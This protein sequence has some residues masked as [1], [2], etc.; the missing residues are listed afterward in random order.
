MKHELWNS[1]VGHFG[2]KKFKCVQNRDVEHR[3]IGLL[4][5]T[6]QMEDLDQE[7]LKLL[8][9]GRIYRRNSWSVFVMFSYSFL[10]HPL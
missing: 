9:A 1:T 7:V 4:S 3:F 2:G 8:T 6:A 10:K 5:I